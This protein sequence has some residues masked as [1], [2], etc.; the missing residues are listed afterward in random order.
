MAADTPHPGLVAG[1]GRAGATAG[2]S[3]IKREEKEDEEN[4]SVAD[5]EEDKKD[6]KAPRT[7]TRCQTPP[8]GPRTHHTP[9]A[10]TSHVHTDPRRPL[11]ATTSPHC[12]PLA[13]GSPPP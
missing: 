2:V 1:L 11:Q 13:P 12:L 3:E 4:A 9:H 6:L 10:H 7:R 8:P 5:A